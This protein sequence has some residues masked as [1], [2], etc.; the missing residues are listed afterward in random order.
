MS[1]AT[2]EQAQVNANAPRVIVFA[3]PNGSGK[4]TTNHRV[5]QDPEL[6]FHGEYINADDIAKSLESEISDYHERNVKAAEIAEQRRQKA[7]QEGRPFAFETVMS[8]P[9]KVAIMA[10]AKA[11]GYDVSLVFVTTNDPEINIKR[12]A[13]RVAKGGHSVKPDAIRKRYRSAMALLPCALEHADTAL[14]VDNSYEQP[15]DVALKKNDGHLQVLSDN[16]PAWVS[17]KLLKPYHAREISREQIEKAFDAQCASSASL[18]AV[19]ADAD[20]S[21]GKTYRG[22]IIEVTQHH[23][24]QQTEANKF[25]VHDRSLSVAQELIV[26]QQATIGY[27]YDKGKIAAPTPSPGLAR[28]SL[29]ALGD[30]QAYKRAKAPTRPALTQEQQ[31]ALRKR[32]GDVGRS[33]DATQR[34]EPDDG[35][36]P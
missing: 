27:A 13:V 29:S 8:T 24:L 16:P 32:L 15:L 33:A 31:A 18:P 34:P 22:T 35:P 4:S 9:E 2:Y 7:M 30:R 12:V 17:E 26:G 20:A 21:N 10:Q 3:G 14:I 19:L 28:I 25:I 11:R 5:L 1:G 6:N 23:A 36:S